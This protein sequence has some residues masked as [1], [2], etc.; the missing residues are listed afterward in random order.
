MSTETKA[1]GGFAVPKPDHA[2]AGYTILNF[3]V[4]DIDPAGNVLSVLQ[5]RNES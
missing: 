2:P 1:F 4:D 3:G 5:E